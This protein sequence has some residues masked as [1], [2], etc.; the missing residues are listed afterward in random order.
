MELVGFILFISLAT[1][2]VAGLAK[3]PQPWG[4]LAV[5]LC[6]VGLGLAAVFV[7]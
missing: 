1:G 2:V 3:L 5:L 7:H 4:G 6:F